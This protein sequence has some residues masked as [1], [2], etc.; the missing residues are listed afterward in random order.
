MQLSSS[1][2]TCQQHNAQTGVDTRQ[3]LQLLFPSNIRIR[4]ICDLS[5]YISI[6][7]NSVGENTRQESSEDNVQ[8]GSSWQE[9]DLNSVNHPLQT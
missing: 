6:W 9:G 7:E 2:I 5:D 3:E 8:N 4:K 1:Q